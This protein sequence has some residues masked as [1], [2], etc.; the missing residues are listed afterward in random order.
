MFY[1][2]LIVFVGKVNLITNS[3]AI[4]LTMTLGHWDIQHTVPFIKNVRRALKT[5]HPFRV[6]ILV[7]FCRG[8][9]IPKGKFGL[10]LIFTM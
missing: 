8:E 4:Q 6:Q 2:L 10:E 9:G 3:V 1:R 7:D 5:K